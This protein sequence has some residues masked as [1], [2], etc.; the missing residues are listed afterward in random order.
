[1]RNVKGAKTKRHDR[2]KTKRESAKER[3]SG[4]ERGERRERKRK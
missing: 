4:R 3:G 2:G 1:M